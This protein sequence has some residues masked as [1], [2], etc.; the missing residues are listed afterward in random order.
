MKFI[1]FG[2]CSRLD[3]GCQGLSKKKINKTDEREVFWQ[4]SGYHEAVYLHAPGH[5]SREGPSINPLGNDRLEHDRRLSRLALLRRALTALWLVVAVGAA[6]V[7]ILCGLGIIR[8]LERARAVFGCVGLAIAVLG[9]AVAHIRSLER[10]A[11]R[12]AEPEPP[13]FLNSHHRWHDWYHR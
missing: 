5:I 12:L 7:V 11:L 2:Q 4:G 1:F 9:V 8:D 13:E 6:V 10:K 3:D